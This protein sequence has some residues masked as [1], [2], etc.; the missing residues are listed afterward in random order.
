MFEKSHFFQAKTRSR[1]EAEGQQNKKLAGRI[2]EQGQVLQDDEF[3][4][5]RDHG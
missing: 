5:S 3:S 2:V 1:A 4:N